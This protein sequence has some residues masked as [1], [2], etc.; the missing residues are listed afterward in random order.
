MNIS[1]NISSIQIDQNRMNS[2]AQE[3]D[4][5]KSIPK[6]INVEKSQEANV[7]A[8]RTQDDMLGTL[9]DIKV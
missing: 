9:L 3:K 6:Q 5:T 1:N 7:T 8:I 2:L 4:L